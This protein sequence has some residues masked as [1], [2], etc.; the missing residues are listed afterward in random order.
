MSLTVVC[1]SDWQAVSNSLE[2][3]YDDAMTDGKKVLERHGIEWF[4]N[5]FDGPTCLYE[6]EQTP[7]IST[8]LY[9][10]CAGPYKVY[11]DYDP[12]YVP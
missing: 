12:M 3:R 9:A 10:L 8:Y 2:V 4:L 1:P 5:F 11:T 7:R 6:Y